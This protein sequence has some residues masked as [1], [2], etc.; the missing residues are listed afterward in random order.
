MPEYIHNNSDRGHPGQGRWLTPDVEF[1][2]RE[3]LVEDLIKKARSRGA[4]QPG[5]SVALYGPRLVGKSELLKR[6]YNGLFTIGDATI[7]LYLSLKEVCDEGGPEEVL[8]RF[9]RQYGAFFLRNPN[10]VISELSLDDTWSMLLNHQVPELPDILKLHKALK[11]SGDDKGLMKNILNLP[12]IMSRAA[13]TPVSLIVDDIHLADN[14]LHKG[15][16][17]ASALVS[18]LKGPGVSM[19]MSTPSRSSVPSLIPMGPSVETVRLAP[20]TDGSSETMITSICSYHGLPCSDEAVDGATWLLSGN[21]LYIKSLVHSGVAAET[22]ITSLRELVDL[23]AYGLIEGTLGEVL[24]RVLPLQGSVEELKALK[25]IV[26]GSDDYELGELGDAYR[27]GGIDK[28]AALLATLEEGGFISRSGGI[29]SW[30]G[31]RVMEDLIGYLYNRRVRGCSG[32][33]ALLILKKSL[34]KEGFR[35]EGEAIRSDIVSEVKEVLDLFN[36]QSVPQ[37]LFD[38]KGFKCR[39]GPASVPAPAE[40]GKGSGTAAFDIYNINLP[41]IVGTFT[42]EEGGERDLGIMD[43][44]SRGVDEGGDERPLKI[45]S[46]SGFE[47]GGYGTDSEVQWLV[48]VKGVEGPFNMGDLEGFL[49]RTRTLQVGKRSVKVNLWLVASEDFT[50]EVLRKISAEGGRTLPLIKT[51]SR[52]ELSILKGTLSNELLI[53][54]EVDGPAGVTHKGRARRTE[55]GEEGAGGFDGADKRGAERIDVGGGTGQASQISGTT[56]PI[57]PSS[58]FEVVLPNAPRS[59]LIAVRAVEN[60]ASDMG[61]ADDSITEIKTALVEACI[62]AFEHSKISR[63]KVYVRFLSTVDRLLVEVKNEGL[64]IGKGAEAEAA[65]GVADISMDGGKLALKKRGWGIELMKKLM[66]EVRFVPL[67]GGTKIIMIKRLPVT[68]PDRSTEKGEE[69]GTD[70]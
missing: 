38:R 39:G 63:T 23:Y 61:F 32:D 3:P 60:I 53:S 9:L 40:G 27:E 13:S 47:G 22:S 51:S 70:G 62:N 15:A 14:L 42:P 33:E 67:S 35:S 24:S 66:D 64:P 41:E 48:G 55:R 68:S 45:L 6:V 69:S 52:E 1:F 21:P 2:G 20:L 65:E 4:D 30:L 7:P 28:V 58:E 10:I 29:V 59:E 5:I 37:V 46:A 31:D 56:T 57:G 16:S 54:S 43:L 8:K 34:L 26:D 12:S 19:I 50:G 17:S 36:S 11:K 18:A 44:G 25:M 49:R